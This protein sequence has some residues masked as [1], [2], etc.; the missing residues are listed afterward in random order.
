MEGGCLC[1]LHQWIWHNVRTI[2]LYHLHYSQKVKWTPC[3]SSQRKKK[4]HFPKVSVIPW[5]Y[6]TTYTTL[7]ESVWEPFLLHLNQCKSLSTFPLRHAHL[8]QR[9]CKG[10]QHLGND[11]NILFNNLIAKNYSYCSL[12][13]DPLPRFPLPSPP[14]IYH[15]SLALGKYS[16]CSPN[17]SVN[18]SL[19]HSAWLKTAGYGPRWPKGSYKFLIFLV[20][21]P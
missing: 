15:Q 21:G 9:K 6:I 14:H 5:S 11:I 10:H 16:L 17:I 19:R 1:I 12:P 7:I 2:F 8:I 20:R 18:K 13:T 3:G 4:K